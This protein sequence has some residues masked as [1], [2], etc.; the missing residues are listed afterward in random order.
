MGKFKLVNP[1]I[2]G[3]F[4]DTYETS[5]SD[6]AAKK[7]WESLTSGNKYIAGNI[8][9]FLFTLM[10]MSNKELYHYMVK[11]KLDGQ[12]ANY[13]ITSISPDL[14]KDQKS[15]FLK[16]VQKVKIDATQEGGASDS[17]KEHTKRTR[18]DD[19]SE[20]KHKKKK[21]VRYE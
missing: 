1:V 17:E 10:D 18:D 5:S 19:D 2:I 13:D 12:I 14:T 7:F 4:D 15:N 20:K 3:T 9:K 16:E 6:G 11:E 21:V 8:P